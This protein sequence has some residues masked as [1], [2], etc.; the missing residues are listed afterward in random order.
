MT[1]RR[2]FIS[3]STTRNRRNHVGLSSQSF[4]I[5]KRVWSTICKYKQLSMPETEVL[6]TSDLLEIK[7][8]SMYSH[9]PNEIR[10]EFES[11]SQHGLKCE[12]IL[13]RGQKANIYIAVPVQS[14]VK[15]DIKSNNLQIYL[16]NIIA[17]LNFVSNIASHKCAKTLNVYFLLTNAK[18]QFPEIDTDSIEEIHANTAFTTAC[19]SRNDIFIFRR[20]EWF[21]VFMHETFHCFGLDF[22]SSVGDESNER[23]LSLFPVIEPK[24]DIRL[25]ET[26]CEMWAEVFHILF[27]VFTTKT[28][29]CLEFSENKFRGI[30]NREQHF[31]IYQSNKVLARSN[32]AYKDIRIKPSHNTPLYKENT[33]AF[34]YYVIKSVML[35]NLDRYIKW[36]IQYANV[37]GKNHPPIQFDLSRISEYCD[38][39]DELTSNDGNYKRMVERI[40]TNSNIRQNIIATIKTK[41]TIRMTSIDPKWTLG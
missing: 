7:N 25:Y 33:P 10:D 28:G 1:R 22:S 17:W 27:C 20:E 12:T 40:E 11:S 26:F 31:S 4:Q 6:E 36:C 15:S 34:S 38:L 5:L 9:I 23:I 30:L 13:S 19:S 3:K 35:W 29:K 2:Q 41:N 32:Y 21:K 24:T 16:N 8:N 18:K 39:V 14:N 37:A